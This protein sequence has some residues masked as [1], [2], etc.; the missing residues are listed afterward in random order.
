MTWH[1]RENVALFFLAVEASVV[2]LDPLNTVVWSALEW[3]C[4]HEAIPLTRCFRFFHFTR[5]VVW[6]EPVHRKRHTF[7]TS[8]VR[9]AV[10]G[11]TGLVYIFTA[12]K[13]CRKNTYT[14]THRKYD[15]VD[16]VYE[17][18]ALASSRRLLWSS[19]DP[20]FDLNDKHVAKLEKHGL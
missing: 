18:K 13:P 5:T 10:E 19:K 16:S 2:R 7:G 9:G 15:S 20:T 1:R 17:T 4:N 14:D 6:N 11:L 3:H 12:K 8:L